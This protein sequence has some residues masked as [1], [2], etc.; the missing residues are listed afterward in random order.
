MNKQKDYENRDKNI[1][2]LNE[3]ARKLGKRTSSLNLSDPQVN[4]YPHSWRD[5]FSNKP[6]P[7]DTFTRKLSFR[8]EGLQVTL[9]VNDE[10]L[11]ADIRGKFG[12]DVICSFV[13]N[14]KFGSSRKVANKLLCKTYGHKIFLASY[15]KTDKMVLFLHNPS[16][17]QFVKRLRLSQKESLHFWDG[18]AILYL[19]RFSW[20]EVSTTLS[21][22]YDLL[23][24]LPLRQEETP[25][26]DELPENF[27]KLVPLIKRWGVTDDN[28]RSEKVSKASSITLNRLVATVKPK[29][30][31]INSYLDTFGANPLPEHAILLGALAECAT[32]AQLVLAERTAKKK[33]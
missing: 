33:S 21:I 4:H 10:Y 3:V 11:V 2:F 19:Q 17:Q 15:S 18:Q 20:E 30:R 8:A 7:P 28:D 6:A 1:R 31:A 12:S 16:F 23:L 9:R 27:Q 5:V 24:L 13:N 32:E 14:T 25:Q 29:F 26:F 22:L